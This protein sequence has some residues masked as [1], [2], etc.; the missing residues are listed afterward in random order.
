MTDIIDQIWEAHLRK[1]GQNP[2]KNEP[3]HL[4]RLCANTLESPEMWNPEIRQARANWLRRFATFIER[5]RT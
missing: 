1:I 2:E 5:T 4:L 3:V